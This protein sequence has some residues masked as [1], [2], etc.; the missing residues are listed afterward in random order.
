MKRR[1][2]LFLCAGLICICVAVV[3]IRGKLSAQRVTRVFPAPGV[4]KVVIRA[5]QAEFTEVS[6]GG[7]KQI[8][9]SG[10]PSGGTQGYH[11]SDPSWRETP[12]KS[13][14]LDFV[15]KRYGSVLIISTKSE[16]EYIHHHYTLEELNLEVPKGVTVLKENRRPNGTGDAYLKKPD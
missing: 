3:Y 16:I 9:I 10:I 5:A 8:Q 7:V 12:A 13:W 15:A 4:K 14:G 2:L 1:H 11:P 6:S